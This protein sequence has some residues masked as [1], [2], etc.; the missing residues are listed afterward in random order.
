M[1]AKGVRH[2]IEIL[3]EKKLRLSTMFQII[4]EIAAKLE[5]PTEIDVI[6]NK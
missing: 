1:R 3:G 6:E 5:I 2:K 4:K